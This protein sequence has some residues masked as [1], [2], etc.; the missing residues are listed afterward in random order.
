MT[1]HRAFRF[2]VQSFSATSAKEWK[3]KAR[4]AEDLGYAVLSLADHI[5]G[6]GP[7]QEA[8]MHPPQELAAVPAMAVA[9]E[10]TS[11]LRI[12]CRVFCV[13][14][15]HPVMLA[16]EAA[17]LDL[18]SEGRMEIGLGAG[19]LQGEYEAVGIPFD[20]PGL[21]I[22]RLAEAI[23]IMKQLMAEGE[24]SFEG[25]HFCVKGFD[26]R[27]KPVQ[28][29]HPPI[30]IGGGAKRIL[31][32]AGREANIVSFNFNNRS[33]VIGADG[34]QSSTAELTAQKVEWVREAAGD[35]FSDIELEIAAYFTLVTDDVET[36]S[37][38]MGKVFGLSGEEMRAHPHALF[39]TVDA[40]CEE[41][42]RRR[43][44]YGISYVTVNDIQME[45]F[46]PVV[47]RLAGR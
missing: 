11:S 14:Y 12:A 24:M 34:V 3:D 27:P 13:D 1:E 31:S 23:S 9:A 7:A 41:L 15:R 42:V 46:A 5:F 29:P 20:R 4:L 18:L 2:G 25:E 28:R 30:M 35:R 17:T 45:Q 26:G 6:P 39:G 38:G 21:R 16:K 22:S 32:L 43:E 33:G 47:A 40:I 37:E 19:W 8:T 36:V 10:A 44:L